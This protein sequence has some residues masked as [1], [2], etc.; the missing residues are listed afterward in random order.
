MPRGRPK[1]KVEE[2]KSD[3][4]PKKTEEPKAPVV[5]EVEEQKPEREKFVERPPANDEERIAESRKA[6]NQPLAPGQQFFEAPDGMIIIGEA[7][8]TQVFYRQG[9]GGK[10]MHINPKR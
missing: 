4:Q 7:D 9:N 3:E 5:K 10:G 6:L 8:R 1:K 2:V